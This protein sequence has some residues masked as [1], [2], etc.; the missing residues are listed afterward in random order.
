MGICL[1]P[2]GS[3][4][5][6]LLKLANSMTRLLH[7]PIK[8]SLDHGW[9]IRGELMVDKAGNRS[10]DRSKRELKQSIESIFRVNGQETT[11]PSSEKRDEDGEED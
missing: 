6:N 10:F 2:N 8:A 1:I 11:L 7:I 3:M 4:L 9:R 5:V